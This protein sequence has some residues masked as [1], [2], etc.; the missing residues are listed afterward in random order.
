[1]LERSLLS[2][3][4]F[5]LLEENRASMRRPLRGSVDLSTSTPRVEGFGRRCRLACAFPLFGRIREVTSVKRVYVDKSELG[6]GC[7]FFLSFIM[8]ILP[9]V[10]CMDCLIAEWLHTR[11]P[12][13]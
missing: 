10:C 8:R 3:D 7:K 12:C 4:V 1:M 11:I 6:L 2:S 13:M 9:H 5:C